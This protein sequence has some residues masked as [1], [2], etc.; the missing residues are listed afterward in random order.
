MDTTGLNVPKL[1]LIVIEQWKSAPTFWPVKVLSISRTLELEQRLGRKLGAVGGYFTCLKNI[2]LR[3]P[4]EMEDILGFQK[5]T[6]SSGVSVWKLN[7]LPKPDEFELRGYTQTPG[8]ENFDG[9]VIRRSDLRRPQYVLRDG[10]LAKFPP[11]LAVEQWELAKN[12]L[13][14]ATELERVPFGVKFTKWA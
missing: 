4:T 7:D 12:V 6:F 3:T 9:I 8:G 1:K 14:P 5:G 10:T 2:R 13:L 11:G